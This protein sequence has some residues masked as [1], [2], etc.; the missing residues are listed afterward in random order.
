MYEKWIAMFG[1]LEPY[2]DY[3]KTGLPNLTVN[4]NGQL[5]VI[6][7]RYPTPQAERVGN[8]NAPVPSLSTP[9][10]WAQ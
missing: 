6:P 8:P 1:S 9:V 4:P 7:K 2:N 5:S 3:R 10:W